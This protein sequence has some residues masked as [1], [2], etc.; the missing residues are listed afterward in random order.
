MTKRSPDTNVILEV[1]VGL[2]TKVEKRRV[3]DGLT[4]T[5]AL[6]SVLLG[7]FGRGRLTGIV[8]VP[9]LYLEWVDLPAPRERREIHVR[10]PPQVMEK[11][12][13]R[14]RLNFSLTIALRAKD[15]HKVLE[16][17]EPDFN[18]MA[19]A[20]DGWNA[21]P[22]DCIDLISEAVKL[23]KHLSEGQTDGEDQEV[24]PKLVGKL[25]TLH[26]SLI[27]AVEKVQK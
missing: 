7:L 22:S 3:R 11:A 20:A 9:A 19:R 23:I 16:T 14:W 5:S 12:V 10:V 8:N 18:K 1:R 13:G 26:S 21:I 2:L 24:Y 6:I 15:T 25:E 27:D 17:L 4:N